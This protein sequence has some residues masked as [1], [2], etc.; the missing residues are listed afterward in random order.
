MST[1]PSTPPSLLERVRSTDDCEAWYRFVDLYTPLLLFW[2]RRLGVQ[3]QDR[4][5]L[6]QDIFRELIKALPKF[7]Y[8]PTLRFRGYLFRVTRAKVADHFR[9]VAQVAT[10]L[11]HENQLP[12]GT[13]PSEQ[14][15]E[16]D[17]NAQV[18]RRAVQLIAKDFDAVTAIAFHRYMIEEETP[19]AIAADMK[20]STNSV[21]QARYR[22]LKR[23]REEFGDLFE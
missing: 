5:D 15:I 16:R 22:V 23:L 12:G 3:N 10:T 20:I 9:R 8:D 11:D 1:N 17:Y 2:V 13:D 18:F 19:A 6:V 7:K 4:A 14:W 21:Y